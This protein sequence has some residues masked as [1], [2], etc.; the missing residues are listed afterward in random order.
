MDSSDSGQSPVADQ[1][2]VEGGKFQVLC[3]TVHLLRRAM[4]YG[5]GVKRKEIS[6]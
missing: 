4:R 3:A 1:C 5:L 2:S 6:N